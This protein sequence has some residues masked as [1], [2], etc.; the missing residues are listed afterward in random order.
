MHAFTLHGFDSVSWAFLLLSD[1]SGPSCEFTSFRR[2]CFFAFRSVLDCFLGEWALNVIILLCGYNELNLKILSQAI[3]NWHLTL[4]P[5]VWTGCWKVLLTQAWPECLLDHTL[6]HIW[7]S[8]T[9]WLF[10]PSYLNSLCLHL[11]R[12]HQKLHLL[13]SS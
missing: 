9:M 2:N 6:S 3:H 10:L 12:W 13:G 5:L 1:V 8:P 7:T 11:R 4:L